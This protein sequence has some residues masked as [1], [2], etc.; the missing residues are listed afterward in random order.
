[1][2]ATIERSNI[3][4]DVSH[5]SNNLHNFICSA[6]IDVKLPTKEELM[7]IDDVVFPEKATNNVTNQAQVTIPGSI[8]LRQ[9]EIEGIA[10][11]RMYTFG[12]S[13]Y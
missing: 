5:N 9:F 11:L 12:N 2:N 3:G 1:M 6:V 4:K 13:L 8:L 7:T 10:V